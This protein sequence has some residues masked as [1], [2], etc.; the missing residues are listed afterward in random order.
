MGGK[1]GRCVGLTTLPPSYA[2]CLKSETMNLLETPGLVE[3][4]KG[5]A[6][7]FTLFDDVH[8]YCRQSAS[9]GPGTHRHGLCLCVISVRKEYAAHFQHLCFIR[10]MSSF[11]SRSCVPQLLLSVNE[12]LGLC[13]SGP[14]P[15]TLCCTLSFQATFHL[16]YGGD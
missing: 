16:D 10:E 5:I 9:I 4:S 14:V 8:K 13:R 15:F 6:L 12:V 1:G 3:A 11:C 2:D 7:P